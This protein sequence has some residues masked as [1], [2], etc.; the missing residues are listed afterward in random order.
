MPWNPK[1]TRVS[2]NLTASKILCPTVQWLLQDLPHVLG[3]Q[4]QGRLIANP[5]SSA[6]IATRLTFLLKRKPNL[7]RKAVSAE[8]SAGH[9]KE[10]LARLIRPLSLIVVRDK[11]RL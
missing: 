10:C 9:R 3:K 8:E 5:C 2:L 1:K 11:V 6:S 7:A 4:L